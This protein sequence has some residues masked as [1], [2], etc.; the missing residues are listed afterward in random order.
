VQDPSPQRCCTRTDHRTTCRNTE[1]G[2]TLACTGTA[3]PPLSIPLSRLRGPPTSHTAPQSR[4]VP[5]VVVEMAQGG[6]L[7]PRTKSSRRSPQ[8]YDII[9]LLPSH[10]SRR[11]VAQAVFRRCTAPEFPAMP[12]NPATD[13]CEPSHLWL[14]LSRA[15]SSDAVPHRPGDRQATPGTVERCKRTK[16]GTERGP[17]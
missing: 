13:C 14:P 12:R 3:N 15:P 16:A 1:P 9:S 4:L 6:A 7:P 11:H 5:K 10:A 17:T 8:R 2:A